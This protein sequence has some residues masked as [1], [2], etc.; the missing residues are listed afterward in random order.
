MGLQS[1]NAADLKEAIQ[2]MEKYRISKLK[3]WR[4]A[5]TLKTYLDRQ[6]IPRLLCIKKLPTTMY[7]KDFLSKWN[8]ILSQCSLE[9]IQLII[10]F[11]ESK[12][13]EIRSDIIKLQS[14]MD[15]KFSA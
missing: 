5:N 4:D 2:T 1:P 6:M 7:S 11:E 10:Q 12:L 14:S 8:S 15:E 13:L 9:L 3:T